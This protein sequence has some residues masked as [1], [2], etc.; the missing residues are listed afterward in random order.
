ME[1]DND[2]AMRLVNKVIKKKKLCTM[3][4]TDKN[5]AP[6]IWK[7][8]AYNMQMTTKFYFAYYANPETEFLK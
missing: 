2:K 1:G 5:E 3:F 7:A 6:L 4:M 8:L